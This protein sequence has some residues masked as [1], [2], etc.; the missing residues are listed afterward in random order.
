MPIVLDYHIVYSRVSQIFQICIF[1]IRQP[2]PDLPAV[3]RF[4]RKKDAMTENREKYVKNKIAIKR[5]PSK[6]APVSKMAAIPC[7]NNIGT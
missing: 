6:I 7:A 5:T 4:A 2:M 1:N 3:A